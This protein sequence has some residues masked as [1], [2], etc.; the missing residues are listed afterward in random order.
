MKKTTVWGI[1]I[2]ILV[3]IIVVVSVKSSSK[4]DVASNEPIKIGF[5]GPLTGD[6]AVYG[7]TEKNATQMALDVI[8]QS[9]DFAN[10]QVDVIY[11]DGKCNGKD[12]TSAAQKLIHVDNVKFIF[13]GVCSAETLSIAPLAEASKVL[14]FSAFSSAPA[15]T[16]AGDYVFRNSVSDNDS[17]KIDADL[18]AARYKKIAVISEATDYSAGIHT[19]LADLL[20]K[21]GVTIVDDESYPSNT[22]DFRTILLKVKTANPEAVYFN[23]G[24]S[25]QAAGLLI[26][27][28]RDIG[29]NV[30]AYSN[31]FMG[32]P[33]AIKAAGPSAEGVI[34]SDF[35]GLAD[36]KKSLIDQYK[37]RF[38][39][40]P[41][42]D[43]E[44][45][46]AYDRVFILLQAIKSVGYD[47]TKVKDYLYKMDDYD[48]SI[49]KYHFDQ[50]GDISGAGFRHFIIKDGKKTP[51]EVTK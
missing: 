10:R 8:K 49:G 31:F 5:V 14:L 11:E 35:A 29:L 36:D 1:I 13:G 2:L 38:G 25:P 43:S 27:Q 6:A 15:I 32:N 45:G 23:A 4:S 12:A 39:S 24:T 28:A 46:T 3:I 17:G 9:P 33:D 37:A 48:G 7:T 19:V 21:K 44:M 51:Y 20:G 26:K 40:A 47:A 22:K 18:L 41:G 16:D 42:N 50:N 34:F 30:P